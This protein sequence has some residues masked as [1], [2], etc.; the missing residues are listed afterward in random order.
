[1]LSCKCGDQRV[2]CCHA[3]VGTSLLGQMRVLHASGGSW[4]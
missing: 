2:L 4:E 1:M 3:S